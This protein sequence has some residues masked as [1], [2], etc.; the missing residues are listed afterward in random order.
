MHKFKYYKILVPIFPLRFGTNLRYLELPC[1]LITIEVS[2][3][4]VLLHHNL[5][6]YLQVLSRE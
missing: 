5:Y 6:T 1:D 4:P 2:S 3:N